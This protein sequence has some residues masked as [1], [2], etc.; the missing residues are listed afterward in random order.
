MDPTQARHLFLPLLYSIPQNSKVQ[1]D[2]KASLSSLCNLLQKEQC[3]FENQSPKIN[4]FYHSLI[5]STGKLQRQDDNG[6]AIHSC[7]EA[8]SFWT[9]DLL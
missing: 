1:G 4:P 2:K 8:K 9:L 3:P 6:S 5:N 7:L